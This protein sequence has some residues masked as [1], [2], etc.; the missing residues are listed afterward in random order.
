M[1]GAGG[2]TGAIGGMLGEGGGGLAE[3]SPH[4]YRRW[5]KLFDSEKAPAKSR[6]FG[7]P[8]GTPEIAPDVD[9]QMS[10]CLTIPIE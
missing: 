10:R 3:K 9:K 5:T 4:E 2:S 1:A 6:R 8:G 7:V